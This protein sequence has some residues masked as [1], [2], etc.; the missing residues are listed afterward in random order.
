MNTILKDRI[1]A[2]M[3]IALP[4]AIGASA[5]YKAASAV[6]PGSV[7]FGN[8]IVGTTSAPTQVTF[9]NT[10]ASSM[11]IVGVSLSLIQFAYS[12]PALPITLNPGQSFTGK[13]T[14][15]PTGAQAYTGT[16]VFT[17]A[18]GLTAA[19]KLSGTGVQQPA[20]AAPAKSPTSL[21][22]T[23]APC[24]ANFNCVPGT[25]AAAGQWVRITAHVVYQG[26]PN[27]T[28]QLCVLDDN[29]PA[30]Y[31]LT[32]V[33]DE[34]WFTN[35]LVAGK[36][37]FAA[38]YAGDSV[39]SGSTST[40]STLS[41]GGAVAPV[42]T[43][44]PPAITSQPA[45]QSVT[46]GQVATFS[47][48][49]SGTAPLSYQWKKNN[50]A[51]SGAT[52]ASYATPVTTTS[53]NGAQF[54]LTVSNSVS[55]VTSSAAT[56][57]VNAGSGQL[58]VSPSS[59]NFGNVNTGSNSALSATLTNS[60]TSSATISNVSV[61]GAGFNATGLSGVILGPGQS[62]NVSVT[63]APSGTGAV[64]GTVTIT[65]NAANSPKG[66][67]LSGSGVQPTVTSITI[68]PTNQTVPVGTQVQFKAV[69]NF[70]NDITTSVL[71]SSSNSS[72]VSIATS[73]LATGLADGSS[74]I[75]GTN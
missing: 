39:Y 58:T 24:D 62:T 68:T 43:I 75:S 32:P 6:T 23:V 42:S 25:T 2:V 54:T 46:A 56:L 11:E 61:S 51:I 74:V 36:Q 38:T 50:T 66:I 65:S 12:G 35:G 73:G 15:S 8:Q 72:I 28:G 20:S 30:N 53:D 69:D 13:V 21:Q 5:R 60:G 40:S 22:L 16:L 14:F 4:F 47:A 7:N 29:S 70:G 71:W 1:L 55:S 18:N 37:T 64:S 9:S 41:V 33:T 19:S 27:P 45:N 49:V 57:T 59:L 17:R 3:L 10:G 67:T 48:A 52:S 44:V 26:T 63:F 34:N 31:G